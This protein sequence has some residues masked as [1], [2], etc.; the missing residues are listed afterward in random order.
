MNTL[1]RI[2]G[3][4]CCVVA[5]ALTLLNC[6]A[7]A[8][9]YLASGDKSFQS[10]K[11]SEAI[12]YYRNAIQ[13]SPKLAR[14]HY[15]LARA[16]LQSK[17]LQNAYKELQETVTLD[18]SNSE[19]QLQF[20]AVL[21]AGKKYDEAKAAIARVLE[22]DP[23]NA[24]AH[25]ILG[26][27]FALRGNAPASIR[28]YHEAIR[29]NPHLIDSYASLAT[30]QVSLGEPA[31]AENILKLGVESNPKSA[32]AHVNLA[33]FDL[34]QRRFAEARSELGVASTLAPKDPLPRLLTANVWVAE[35]NSA[36]A[37]KVC[38]D[39]RK[40]APD[41]PA[42]YRAL[43][44]LYAATH[45]RAKAVEELQSLRIAKPKDSWVRIHLAQTLVELNR[46]QDASAVTEELLSSDPNDPDG[47]LLRGQIFIAGR[48][49]KA[50]QAAILSAIKGAPQSAP[51]WYFLGVAQM[52]D[53]L[54]DAAKGSFAQA[55]KL[56]PKTVGPEA[57]LAELDANAGN[58]GTAERLA[59]SN[60][61]LPVAEI[62]GAQ[63]EL[64]KG[65]LH[66]A[67]EMALAA[68]ERDPVSLRALEI[69]EKAQAQLGRP[70]DSVKRLSGLVS[71]FSNNAELRFLLARACFDQHDLQKAEVSVRQAIALDPR[72]PDA[73]SLLAEIDLAKGLNAEAVAE[74]RAAI[75]SDPHKVSNYLAV[76]N[77]YKAASRWEDA[78]KA[79]EKA[80]TV[81]SG[82]PYVKN[83]LANQYLEHGG[84]LNVALSLAQQAKQALP[85]SPVVAD[86]LGW[87]FYKVGSYRSAIEQLSLSTQKAPENAEYQYHLGVAYL[88]AGRMEPAAQSLRRALK[89]NPTFAYADNARAALDRIAKQAQK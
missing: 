25:S 76:A 54:T 45:Q 64:A 8:D 24:E 47:L 87:A 66:K 55:H 26:D 4:W 73:H 62:L 53:G 59:I 65:N 31:E 67:E 22:K 30:I 3:K 70:Q 20:A 52:A 37:E 44:L 36:N 9:K 42:A 13:V 14:A 29:L 28:E 82:S 77:L 84:D 32:G 38:A 69:L 89:S 80:N 41:D 60:P 5:L 11:Y 63:E 18:P 2:S 57:A 16:Y 23:N 71:Q 68:L 33:K 10:G 72:T 75:D 1:L 15:Q 21:I 51:A 74:F 27:Q 12:V 7:S 6:S 79:L 81:D 34:S 40:L 86:T 85:D 56:S 46:M 88:G 58:Y 49:Y 50:A 43:A 17:F 61:D 48:K 83:N 78:T 35:G 39:L 19:A